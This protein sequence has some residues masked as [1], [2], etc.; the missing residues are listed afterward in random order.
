MGFPF[1][2]TRKQAIDY[3]LDF[4]IPQQLSRFITLLQLDMIYLIT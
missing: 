4:L 2:Q 1:Y 3:L